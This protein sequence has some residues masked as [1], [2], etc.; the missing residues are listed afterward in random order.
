[1]SASDCFGKLFDKPGCRDSVNNI[2]VKGNSHTKMFSWKIH[3]GM[4]MQT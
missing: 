3:N 1:M 4:K 2:V